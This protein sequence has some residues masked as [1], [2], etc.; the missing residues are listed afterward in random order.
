MGEWV[1][2]EAVC[3]LSINVILVRFGMWVYTTWHVWY[4]KK[5][6]TKEFVKVMKLPLF[7]L[8]FILTDFCPQQGPVWKAN[9]LW[10]HSNH[11][12]KKFYYITNSAINSKRSWKY[13]SVCVRGQEW[14][15]GLAGC[16]ICLHETC[17]QERWQPLIKNH[18]NE[19]RGL[20]HSLLPFPQSTFSIH[21]VVQSWK[22]CRGSC[23]L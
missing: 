16:N 15:Q 17:S 6:G 4:I 12:L 14:W 19:D 23:D 20:C 5:Q 7:L 18:A 11:L 9:I 22:S 13:N 1:I 8:A 3:S 10:R 21:V 2:K